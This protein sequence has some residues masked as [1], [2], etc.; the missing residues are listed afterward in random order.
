MIL[1]NTQTQEKIGAARRFAEIMRQGLEGHL[2][3][4]RTHTD[5]EGSELLTAG[6]IARY[7]ELVERNIVA[8]LVAQVTP[9]V[10]GYAAVRELRSFAQRLP[11]TFCFSRDAYISSLGVALGYARQLEATLQ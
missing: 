4:V 3:A 6:N 1:P 11:E 5:H 7:W 8:P 2:A 10:D 9:G